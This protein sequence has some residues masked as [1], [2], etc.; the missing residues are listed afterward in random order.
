[1]YTYT[2]CLLMYKYIYIERERELYSIL[3]YYC[4]HVI[5]CS[6]CSISYG[7]NMFIQYVA[8]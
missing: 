6:S 3:V 1:M 8:I 7:V 2:Y 4:K 5:S